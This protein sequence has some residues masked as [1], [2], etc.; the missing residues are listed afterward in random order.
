M[1]SGQDGKIEDEAG[2]SNPVVFLTKKR[3]EN[4]KNLF[5]PFRATAT[6]KQPPAETQKEFY[7]QVLKRH[8]AF[9]WISRELLSLCKWF[10]LELL[11]LLGPPLPPEMRLLG[12]WI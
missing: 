1:L 12:N 9:D 11:S 2:D 6:L 10:L 5:H 8:N 7:L 4:H 3:R